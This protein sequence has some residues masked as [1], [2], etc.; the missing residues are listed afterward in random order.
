MIYLKLIRWPNL[1]IMAFT[2]I[3][4]RHKLII[5]QLLEAGADTATSSITFVFLVISVLLIAAGGFVINDIVDINADSI[6]K[7]QKQL[8][9]NKISVSIAKNIYW[10]L[11][12]SGII[13]GIITGY[14]VENWRIS[15]I[16]AI[17]AGLMWFYSSRYKNMLLLGNIVVA[18][19]S[20]MVLLIIWLTEF[21][22]LKSDAYAFTN[23][24]PVFPVITGMVMAYTFFAFLCSII[25]E[26]VKDTEDMT[27]D[28]QF[29]VNTFPVVYGESNAKNTATGL[30]AILMLMIAFWQFIL[31]Q[32]GFHNAFLS[33]FIAAA[34][35]VLAIIRIATANKKKHYSQTSFL[36]KL[37]MI[38]GI[39]SMLFL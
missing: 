10:I 6:N 14:A 19:A 26:M 7:P 33:M 35:C 38:S 9:G 15:F 17:M 34:L 27:G 8:V 22:A 32:Q 24:A 4:V 23:A 28:K 21:F 25:R 5:P 39:S 29:N 16:T 13:C 36:L 37:L 11:T 12:A 30:L 18:F 2:M 3:L 31:N 20:A 1:L